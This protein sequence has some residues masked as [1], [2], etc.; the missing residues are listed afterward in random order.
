M[1]NR[2]T[3]LT[4]SSS[5]RGGQAY[6]ERDAPGYYSL[7]NGKEDDDKVSVA[8]SVI[9]SYKKRK[10]SIQ[11]SKNETPQKGVTPREFEKR[12]S[13]TIDRNRYSGRNLDQKNLAIL[14]GD[15]GQLD[16]DAVSVHSGLFTSKASQ[17][18]SKKYEQRFP[19][20]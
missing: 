17:I 7:P 1:S 13:H 8:N 18:S 19:S 5:I 6:G 15:S 10:L 12:G 3:Q 20:I 14:G 4:D 9:S 16:L 11:L 2:R